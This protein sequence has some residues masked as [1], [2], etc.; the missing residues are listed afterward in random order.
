MTPYKHPPKRT[1][2]HEPKPWSTKRN[3]NGELPVTIPKEKPPRERAVSPKRVK[4]GRS[5]EYRKWDIERKRKVRVE[6]TPMEYERY[7]EKRRRE[8]EG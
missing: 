8:R 2:L 3:R 4:E 5:P 7:L 6:R 1:R